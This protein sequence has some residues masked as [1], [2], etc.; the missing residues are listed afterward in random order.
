[1]SE[2]VCLCKVSYSVLIVLSVLVSSGSALFTNR[3][4]LASW[5][6]LEVTCS[7]WLTPFQGAGLKGCGEHLKLISLGTRQSTG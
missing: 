2:T 4:N 7:M 1:M 3:R 6:L 5:C